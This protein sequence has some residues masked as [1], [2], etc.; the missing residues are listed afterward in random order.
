[1][2]DHNF[3]HF[4]RKSVK[5]YTIIILMLSLLLFT[6]CSK[7]PT[8]AELGWDEDWYRAGELLGVEPL[9]GFVLN[10]SGDVLSVN[11]V[12][13]DTWVSGDERE[14][15]NSDGKISKIYDAQIY[16]LT[17]LC[18]S[19]ELA[20]EEAAAWIAREKLSY[21]TGEI[22]A[23]EYGDVRFELLPLLSA[24]ENNPYTHGVSAFAS[25]KAWAICV[26]FLCGDGFDGDPQKIIEQFLN[27]LH[28]IE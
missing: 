6:G 26:E 13:Y 25:H 18:R 21:S 1:M 4:W 28:Y 27:G 7:V 17:E 8:N 12:Y 24:G 20:E 5:R 19:E 15:V 11:G 23:A 2:G 14:Y 10:E 3:R 16:L 9:D 22:S